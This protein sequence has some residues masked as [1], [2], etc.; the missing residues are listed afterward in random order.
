MSNMR[1]AIQG[2]EGSFHHEAALKWYGSHISIVPAQSF[3]QVFTL[4]EKHEVDEAV[5]AIENST[6]GSIPESQEL[7]RSHAYRIVGKIDLP[8]AQQLI[9]LR[10]AQIHSIQEIYSHPVALPQCSVFLE[11]TLPNAKLVPYHDTAASVEL[12]KRMN[13]PSIAAIA[14][15]QAAKLY[16]L[17]ILAGD[18]ENDESN[19]T[20]FVILSGLIN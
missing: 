11:R 13:D 2:V 12:I 1:V 16:D 7:V 8:I 3:Q 17:P 14:S 9:G 20:R 5:I 15:A 6:Y 18:I 4:L 10:D 19:T